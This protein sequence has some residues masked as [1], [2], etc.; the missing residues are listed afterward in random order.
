[1]K[2]IIVMFALIF[3]LAACS[4][5]NKGT[6]AEAAKENQAPSF[7]LKD[8]DG[9]I[10]SLESY[11]G[12]NVYIKFWA[13]W[14]P[15]CLSGL[16]EVDQL[17]AEEPDLVVLTMVAPGYKNE[18]ENEDFIKWFKGVDDVSNM[19]VLLD[20]E[21]VVAKKYQIIGYPT[22]V[23]INKEG[24]LFKTQPGHLSNEQIR[25]QFK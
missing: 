5:E 25:S 14:C 19:N 1:M 8:L 9:N 11:A 10:H 3:V 16:A 4:N 7:E 23:F 22:S 18:K 6:G 17:T 15:I 24:E 2:K 20:D 12:K 21:G 13:S